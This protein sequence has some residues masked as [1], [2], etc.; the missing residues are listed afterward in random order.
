[1][2]T[3]QQIESKLDRILLKVQK[4]GR[5]VGGELNS[6][7]KDWESVAARVA[8]VFPDIYDIGVSNVGLMILYDQINHREDALAER[9]YAP[10]SDME[11]LMRAE[12]IPLYS[13]ESK[14]PLASFDLIG[15]TLPYE[16]LYTNALNIL[17]L[18]G[19]PVRANDRDETHP[20]IIAGGHSTINPE[21]MHAF[22]DA[23]VIGEGEEVIHEIIDVVKSRRSENTTRQQILLALAHLPGVYVP[24]FYESHYLEDGTLSHIETLAEGIANPVVKRIV[25]KLPPPPTRFIVPNIEVV[26]NRVSV[27]ITRGCTRGCRF[28]HAGMITRPVRERSVEEIVKAAREAIQ[29][30]G[31]RGTGAPFPLL[32]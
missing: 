24:L 15:F 12:G 9:A 27:E 20:I 1:M 8:L 3:P 31:F 7:Q 25:P 6:I 4:P 32:L 18:A 29:S 5:Y 17:D 19:I 28:C 2:L 10:W 21:P 16:T 23:F 13:L 11:T 22:I 14:Q 30:T 26:H